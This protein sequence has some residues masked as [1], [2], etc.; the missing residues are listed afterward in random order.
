[1]FDA[2]EL[3]FD[4]LQF[5]F[6]DAQTEDYNF[7]L[8]TGVPLGEVFELYGFGSYGKRNGLSAA[9]YRSAGQNPANRDFS[10]ISPSTTPTP[11]NFTGLTPD[12]FLPLIDTD[13]QDWSGTVGVRGELAGWDGDFSIGYGHN[14]FDFVIRDSLNTSF[15]PASQRDFD[16]GGFDYGQIQANLDFVRQF[17]V[18]LASPLSI[19]V[20]GEYRDE[21]Y[22]ITP[23]ELQSFALG[24][25]FRADFATT[26]TNCATQGGVFNVTTGICSFPGRKAGAGAQGFPGFTTA[27]DE[28][29]DS[30]GGY[31]EFDGELFENFTA[32]VAGRYE[33]FSD[34]G[35]TINGKL[36]LRYEFVDGFAVRGSVSNGFR[37]PS[38]HQQF[39]ATT[40][41]NFISGVPVDISTVAV[42]S[43]VARALGSQ[44]LDPEKSI[45]FSVG[46]TAN[47]FRGLNLTIDYY[48]IAIDD[49]IVLT[50]NLGA[51]GS[52]TP[53]QRAAVQSI[54]NANGFQTVGAARFFING[55]DTTTEGLDV[56]GT[57]RF[58]PGNLGDW[59][60]TA[61]LN[62][63][64][65]KI[66]RRLNAL[67][68]LAAIPGLALFG[69]VEGIRVTDGQPKDKIVLSADGDI[70]DF[71]ITAR[72]TR[73]GEAI[74]LEGTAPLGADAASL[75]ALGP[76]DQVLG[77]KW[78]TDLELRY[79]LLE[80][81]KLAVGANNIFDVYPDRRPFG[82]RP[83][84]GLYPQNFQYIPFSG[85][86]SPFGFNGR[87]LYARIG[88]D[89]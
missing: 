68:P 53:A 56:I 82:R 89:F 88:V 75:T 83:D 28:S 12:G 22:K 50:E 40:S 49:R 52:G 79:D 51:G 64:N 61:A 21:N 87:F 3:S 54:L 32:Q 84:G 34:F 45:N 72:T 10:T 69:R 33:R 14:Q 37:A 30:F 47:P 80:R 42:N 62:L 36:A 20:G 7:F 27:V 38:L 19:A 26:A 1:L 73:Y 77:S 71:G 15:G 70:G 57:Y 11:Q 44:D 2:R 48:N 76:D 43:P 8:N 5:K 35:S 9:N 16:A 81:F 24:P 65:T 67:G 4:R 86:A 85:G 39:F 74:A 60:L 58:S 66:D 25:F 59:T 31:V 29:R 63:N 17:E 18:G 46:A 78:I 23:G 55:I 41:T 13:L 6:G